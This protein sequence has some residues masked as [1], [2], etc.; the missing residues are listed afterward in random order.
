MEA[1]YPNHVSQSDMT[2]VRGASGGLGVSG[3]GDRWKQERGKSRDSRLSLPG[4]PVQRTEPRIRYGSC[5][6]VLLVFAKVVVEG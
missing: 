5:D 4:T 3:R 6:L 1:L 2:K